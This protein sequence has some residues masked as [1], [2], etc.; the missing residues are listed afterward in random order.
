MP[1]ISNVR[2]GTRALVQNTGGVAGGL[3][4]T[5]ALPASMADG[6]VLLGVS[7]VFHDQEGHNLSTGPSPAT[8]SSWSQITDASYGAYVSLSRT[9]NTGTQSPYASHMRLRYYWARY[10]SSGVAGINAAP[11]FTF[12][13]GTQTT[14]WHYTQLIAFTN[15]S[16]GNP[17]DV[18]GAFVAVDATPAVTGT[19]S[20]TV[21]GPATGITTTADG[22]IVFVLV[23]ADIDTTTTG[24]AVVPTMTGDSLTWNEVTELGGS[25]SDVWTMG[26]DYA[27]TPAKLAVSNKQVTVSLT[28]TAKSIGAMVSFQPDT[29]LPHSTVYKPILAM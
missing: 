22:G 1:A 13:S 8:P 9:G 10:D 29:F 15:A 24:T 28:A 6:D 23:I 4:T 5:P 26:L 11:T 18:L 14:D 3:N 25:A 7:V 16:R 21:L 17:V 12:G 19:A 20:S 2:I 27:L